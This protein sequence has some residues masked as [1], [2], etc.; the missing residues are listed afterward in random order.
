M[1]QMKKKVGC[2]NRKCIIFVYAICVTFI[3]IVILQATYGVWL[4]DTHLCDGGCYGL[5]HGGNGV[6]DPPPPVGFG[7]GQH[8]QDGKSHYDIF[9]IYFYP[10]II[11]YRD[12]YF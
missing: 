5:G 1:L 4:D 12:L 7:R 10:I 3:H 11:S 6:E 2:Y 8:E 9:I